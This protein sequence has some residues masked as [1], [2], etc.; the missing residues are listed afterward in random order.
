MENDKKLDAMRFSLDELVVMM[1][2]CAEV[3][4]TACV[5]TEGHFPAASDMRLLKRLR[6]RLFAAVLRHG[7][8]AAGGV[9]ERERTPPHAADLEAVAHV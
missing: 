1:L 3:V 6:K 5:S 8:R 2:A 4:D 9:A 7:R